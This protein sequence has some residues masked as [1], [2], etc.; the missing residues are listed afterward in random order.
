MK[1]AK[2]VILLSESLLS[3]TEYLF[4]DLAELQRNNPE[5]AMRNYQK[6]TGGGVMSFCIEHIGDL[7]HRMTEP[8]ATQGDFGYGYVKDKVNKVL[9]VLKNEYGFWKEHQQNLENN[10]KHKKIDLKE[11]SEK[12]K[13]LLLKYSEE[14]SKLPTYN[15][16]QQLANQ[17]AINLGKE[18]W[19][20]TILNLES[21]SS[22]LSDK[23]NYIKEASKN[24]TR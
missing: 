20:A 15:K 11:F 17:A 6:Y 19:K 16:V 8:T 22:F 14:H 3:D 1:L 24:E 9:S 2:Q 7:I 12:S 13:S 5:E 23:E 21:L 10:A 18:D 4:N